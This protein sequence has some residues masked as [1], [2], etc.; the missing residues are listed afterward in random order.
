MSCLSLMTSRSMSAPRSGRGERRVMCGQTG[1]KFCYRTDSFY[2]ESSL[3]RSERSLQKSEGE[4]EIPGCHCE[5]GDNENDKARYR[6]G[7]IAQNTSHPPMTPG[8]SGMRTPGR[9]QRKGVTQWLSTCCP[10]CETWGPGRSGVALRW[11]QLL[12]AHKER[13]FVCSFLTDYISDWT[14]SWTPRDLNPA[15]LASLAS[16]HQVSETLWKLY[17]EYLMSIFGGLYIMLTG[18]YN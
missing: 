15:S 18:M 6:W 16:D 10:C 1:N 17:D 2:L 4:D 3:L 7:I 12:I 14:D 5:G 8:G 13:P 9:R 11:R